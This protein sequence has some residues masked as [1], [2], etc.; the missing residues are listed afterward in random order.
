[1]YVIMDLCPF[2]FLRCSH[3]QS[4]PAAGSSQFS[5][6]LLEDGSHDLE[7]VIFFLAEFQKYG[8]YL[9]YLEKH[10]VRRQKAF[11]RYHPK[12]KGTVQ[13]QNNIKYRSL[14]LSSVISQAGTAL[15]NSAQEKSDPRN[16]SHGYFFNVLNRTVEL[17]KAYKNYMCVPS[18]SSIH[19]ISR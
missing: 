19:K 17:L 6:Y 12:R 4:C 2:K 15:C 9:L 3:I 13:F 16:N 11:L 5:Q 1:M 10:Y 18:S 7:Y 14:T 8:F